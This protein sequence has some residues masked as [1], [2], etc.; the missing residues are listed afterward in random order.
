MPL[1]LR[2][3]PNFQMVVVYM[4]IVHIASE[5][6][7]VAKVGGLADVL[8][9]LSKELCRLGHQVEIIIPKYDCLH[10]E[11]LKNLKIQQ[12]VT[13]FDGPYSVENTIWSAD[14]DGLKVLLIEPHH[15]ENFFNRDMIYGCPDDIDRF[16]YFSRAAME[17]LFKSGK[18][19]D[20]LHVHDWP[21]AI[22][23]VLYKDMYMQLGFHVG[24]IVLTMH[25][26][27]HQGKCLPHHLN[28]TGLKGENYLTRDKMQDPEATQDI[29]LLKGAIVYADKITTVSPTYEKEILTVEGAFGLHHTLHE[30]RKKLKGILNGIDVEYWD[31]KKD[32]HLSKTYGINGKN[33]SSVIA[34]KKENKKRLKAQLGLAESDAPLIAT[35]ARLVPQKSPELIKQA[36][37]LTLESQGQFILLGNSPI[38]AIHNEF[39][40]LQTDLKNNKNA[41]I[42]MDKDEALAHQIYASADMFIIPSQFEPCGLTQLIALR[43]GTVPIAR[44]TGGLCD[45]VFDIDT[46]DRP[47]KKRNGF[48]FDRA[49]FDAMSTALKRAIECY[50]KQPEMWQSLM[51]NGM[52]Q[53]VSWKQ[54]AQEY[55]ALYQ[56]LPSKSLKEELK[57]G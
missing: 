12:K 45:T 28:R 42:Q 44:M 50:K 53:D 48:T 49:D 16:T 4:Y 6:T 54:P 55:L 52:R 38:P 3:N 41:S 35:I 43:Y 32:P 36:L 2:Q 8:Q 37:F 33:I 5:L 15:T 47:L 51:M 40:A 24:G 1:W 21:T 13:S 18:Q 10:D 25:N 27:Q 19:P 14:V 34:S 17:Y 57:S 26:M 31:P 20:V 11:H 56:E 30:H 22:V 39:D 29:N 7:P 46:S 9:G 23:P